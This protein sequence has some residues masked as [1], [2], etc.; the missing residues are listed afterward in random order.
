MHGQKVTVKEGPYT[1]TSEGKAWLY[2]ANF[3][4]KF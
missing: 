4:Y 3:N 2:G 1:F